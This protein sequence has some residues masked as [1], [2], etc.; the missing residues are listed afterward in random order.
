[1]NEG[2]LKYLDDIDYPLWDKFVH[3]VEGGTLFH[4]TVWLNKVAILSKYNLSILGYFDNNNVLLA[5][6]AFTWNSKGGYK[7]I[8][9]PHATRHMSILIKE[10]DSKYLSKKEYDYFQ[11]AKTIIAELDKN[12]SHIILVNSINQNDIRPYQWKNYKS[13]INYTYLA[14]LDN[15]DNF[16][17][18][19]KHSIRKQINKALKLEYRVVKQ[20][21]LEQSNKVFDL[22]NIAF[23]RKQINYPYSKS[24]FS[25]F[26]DFLDKNSLC[27][28]Y[29]I[30]YEGKCVAGYVI[31]HF[32]DT[33]YLWLGGADPNHFATGLNQLLILKILE[34]CKNAGFKYFD[35]VGANTEGVAEYKGSYS[36][37]LVFYFG[38]EKIN[39]FIPRIKNFV[40]TYHT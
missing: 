11:V 22:Q 26:L 10:S 17:Y 21:S 36:F 25:D 12:Y 18:N 14:S 29:T 9:T 8:T 16:W 28:T 30:E 35:F 34:D 4:T 6:L 38:L 24:I 27:T 19:F 2:Y 39:G 40:K 15:F 5:G 37:E 1:M 33:V 13:F 23:N 31:L 20:N 7:F 32:K 3:E